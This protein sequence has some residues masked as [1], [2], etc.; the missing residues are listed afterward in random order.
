[1]VF[2]GHIYYICYE[3]SGRFYKPSIKLIIKCFIGINI[4]ETDLNYVAYILITH[5]VWPRIVREG[6]VYIFN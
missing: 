1:M 3:I 4:M 6:S 5:V 2:S